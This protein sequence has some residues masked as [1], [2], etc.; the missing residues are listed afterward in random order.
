MHR[1]ASVAGQLTVTAE[2]GVD[3][4]YR[5]QVRGKDKDMDA[6]KPSILLCAAVHLGAQDESDTIQ[7]I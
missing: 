1:W 7:V 2:S 6:A 5:F 4:G 3:G